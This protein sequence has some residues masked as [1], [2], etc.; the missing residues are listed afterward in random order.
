MLRTHSWRSPQNRI[1]VRRVPGK[2]PPHGTFSSPLPPSSL[3]CHLVLI[4][5]VLPWGSG[6]EGVYL[7]TR[8]SLMGLGEINSLVSS[9]LTEAPCTCGSCPCMIWASGSG[10]S[11]VGADE[12]W[13]C[14]PGRESYF[15]LCFP[16]LFQQGF[17]LPWDNRKL[18]PVLISFFK[19]GS[20]G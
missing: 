1:P 3:H 20:L 14:A 18:G 13:R 9:A 11:C 19:W 15:P 6:V 2:C 10:W 16:G 7:P 4:S 8:G 12:V 17:L 5:I